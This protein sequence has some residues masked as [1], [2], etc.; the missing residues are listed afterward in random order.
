MKSLKKNIFSQ[1]SETDF[2]EEY[3]YTKDE[4]FE[5]NKFRVEE[6]VFAYNSYDELKELYTLLKE[7]YIINKRCFQS[8]SE[9][10]GVLCLIFEYDYDSDKTYS[11]CFILENY[12]K[13]E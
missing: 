5:L 8:I 3:G 2:Y 11:S 10:K 9:S 7:P 4:Y 13:K 12:I 6:N 1:L